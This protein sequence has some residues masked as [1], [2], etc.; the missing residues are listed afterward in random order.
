MLEV[1][2]IQHL[3]FI[4][5]VFFCVPLPVRDFHLAEC[6]FSVEYGAVQESPYRVIRG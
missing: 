1:F 4:R 2:L 3:P 5:Q 6:C